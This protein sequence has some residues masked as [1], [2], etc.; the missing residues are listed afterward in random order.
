MNVEVVH[1]FLVKG[2]DVGECCRRVET[3]LEKNLL[4]RYQEVEVDPARCLRGDDPDFFPRIAAAEEE[5][6]RVIKRLLDELVAAGFSRTAELASLDQGY[7]SKTLHTVVHL[8]DGFIGIDSAF[9]NLAD[10][11]HRLGRERAEQ[12]KKSP[13]GYHL[14]RARGRCHGSSADLTGLLRHFEQ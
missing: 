8:L 13:E 7:I 6:R 2:G 11:S 4:L 9:Y 10:D 12:I 1:E 5:V 3:F 14:V